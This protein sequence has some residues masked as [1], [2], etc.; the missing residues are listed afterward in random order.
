M[1]VVVVSRRF[2]PLVGGAEAMTAQLAQ[3]WVEA[4]CKVTL[5]TAQWEPSWPELVHFNGVDVVRLPQP[6]RRFMGTFC[7]MRRLGEWLRRRR[8][9]FDLVYVSMH[10]HDAYAAVGMGRKLRFP[11]VVRSEGTGWSGDMAFHLQANFGL[12]IRRRCQLAAGFVAPSQ[13]AVQELLEAGY[14][15]ERI[16]RIPNGVTLPALPT[17]EERLRS[18]AVFALTDLDFALPT[19]AKLFVYTGRFH[20][21][22][23]LVSLLEAWRMVVEEVP[24]AHLW[25]IGDGPDRQS[26]LQRV[27]QLRLGTRVAVAGPF[28]IIDDVLAAADGF[29][30]ASREE[31]LSRSMLEAMSFGLPIAACDIP[32]N[33]ELIESH[34]EGILVPPGQTEKLAAAVVRLLTSPEWA[35]QL[36]AAAREKVRGCFSLADVS[37]AHLAWFR[38][39]LAR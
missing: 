31:A 13:A 39:L 32:G 38:E 35:A 1:R 20:P 23:S 5:L 3:S 2:W 17:P 22:K 25:L 15:R 11:V 10:K 14:P 36:G 24:E 37:A 6:Q 16:R 18:R 9:E 33:R 4:G 26:L 27:D 19:N 30:L 29:I 12:K 34:R 7:Y 21:S 8:D 28:E